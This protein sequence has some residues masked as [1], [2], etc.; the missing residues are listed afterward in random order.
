M[1]I[2]LRTDFSDQRTW[3]AL[4]AEI[5]APVGEAGFLAD[6]EFVDDARYSGLAV[7][8]LFRAFAEHGARTF[9]IVA[10]GMTM[11]HPEHPLLIVDLYADRGREF[12]AVPSQIQSIE[13][14][15]SLANM[16]FED[17]AGAVGTDGVFRGF[18]QF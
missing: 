13:N 8:Q 5:Q 1:A 15:L 2:V 10:D 9:A 16:D 4:R 18:S 17:F 7:A 6:V 12:R 11:T 3:E 14:N